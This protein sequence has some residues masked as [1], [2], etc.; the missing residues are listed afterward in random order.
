M[1]SKRNGDP[2]SDRRFSNERKKEPPRE[3]NPN[4][5]EEASRLKVDDAI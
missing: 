2:A 3:H 5:K 1:C 4:Q